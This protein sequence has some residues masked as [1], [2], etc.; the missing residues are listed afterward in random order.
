MCSLLDTSIGIRCSD[1]PTTSH[2]TVRMARTIAWCRSCEVAD[3]R[4]WGR[5]VVGKAIDMSV[6]VRAPCGG[7]FAVSKPFA[8]V[9]LMNDVK[10][11]GC[12]YFRGCSAFLLT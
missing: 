11:E 3:I 10:F 7:I 8:S 6:H 5:F 2:A 4:R 1:V 9:S 12:L